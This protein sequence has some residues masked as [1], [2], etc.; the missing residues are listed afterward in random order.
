MTLGRF[1]QSTERQRPDCGDD[2]VERNFTVLVSDGW[3]YADETGKGKWSWQTERVG[4]ELR[5]QLTA[6]TRA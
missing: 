1:R 3:Q 6:G 4:A 2:Q 5:L